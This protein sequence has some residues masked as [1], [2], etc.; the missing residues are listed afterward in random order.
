[1]KFFINILVLCLLLAGCRHNNEIDRQLTEAESLLH[2]F[3]DSVEMMLAPISL[4]DNL[5]DEQ[6]SKGCRILSVAKVKQGKTFITDNYFQKAIR[7]YESEKDTTALLDMYQLAAVKMRWLGNQDSASIFLNKAIDIASN[8]TNP[9]KSELLIELSNMYAMPSLK[10]NYVKAISHAM[11][12]LNVS[13]TKEERARAL[14]DVGLFYSFIGDND[15]TAI[16][17]EKALSQTDVNDPLFTTYALNYANNPSSDFRRSVEYLNRIKTQSLGK[18]ITLGFIYLNNSQVDSARYYSEV[19]RS[20]YNENPTRYSINTYNNLRLLDQSIGLLNKGIVVPY[21]GTVTNDSISEVTSIQKKI[22]EEQRDYNTRLQIQLLQSKAHRQLLL[23]IGLGILL[24]I[25]IG[26]GIYVW[27]SKRKYLKLKKRLDNIK[28]EQIIAEANDDE[29]DKS[30]D[31][32]RSRMD[33]CIEQFRESKLQAYLDKMAIQYRNS[34]NYPSVKERETAQK[35]L[36]SCFA[37]FIVDLKMTGVK[38]NTEDIVTCIMSCLKESN[39]TI[40]ACLGATGTAIRTRKS[41]L[42]TKLPAEI[43]NLL[44]L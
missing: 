24:V 40:A 21:E 37:D 27:Q 39:A 1:M 30:L 31:L 34:G 19:S 4:D 7:F 2:T 43:L 38:L 22:S 8:V 6:M 13:Q 10:K 29:S 25:V 36:I 18:R 3:T 26:V 32:V 15:S 5:S 42:R 17:M 44:E 14:H 16:Y 11:E 9:T 28:V 41:R 12:A 33:I 23:N 35:I 20:M